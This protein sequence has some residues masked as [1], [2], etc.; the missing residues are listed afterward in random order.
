MYRPRSLLPSVY[1]PPTSPQEACGYDRGTVACGPG[2]ARGWTA[3]LTAHG[4][5]C[6]ADGRL[7]SVPRVALYIEV[8]LRRS[9]E[10]DLSV[11]SVEC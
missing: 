10:D 2:L 9:W 8:P 7:L 1:T 11:G 5:H 4:I 6:T 3:S